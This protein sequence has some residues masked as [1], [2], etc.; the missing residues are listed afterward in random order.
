[1]YVFRDGNYSRVVVMA[2]TGENRRVLTDASWG[3]AEDPCW[4]PDGRHIVF[5]SDSHGCCSSSTCTTLSRTSI[6]N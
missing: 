2:A 1:M 6:G 4:A 3:N 5:A